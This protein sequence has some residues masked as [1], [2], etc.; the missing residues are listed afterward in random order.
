MLP[1]TGRSPD[2]IFPVFGWN[3]PPVSLRTLR[4]TLLQA[5]RRQ[6]RLRSTPHTLSSH[7]PAG[8]RTPSTSRGALSEDSPELP[9][10]NRSRR[11]DRGAG[12]PNPM[13]TS[14]ALQE[15]LKLSAAT[16]M[17]QRKLVGPSPRPSGRR[18]VRLGHGRPGEEV[19]GATRCGLETA[20]CTAL[21]PRALAKP[22]R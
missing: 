7:K 3:A 11:D 16:T 22:S 6:R 20:G 9:S 14:G 15:L 1:E 13:T 18:L 8:T 19:T 17:P 10:S 21:P 4:P 5:P 2:G 12:G